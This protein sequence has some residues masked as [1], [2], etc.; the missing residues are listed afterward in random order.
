MLLYQKGQNELL[1][2]NVTSLM[3]LTVVLM[4]SYNRQ[5]LLDLRP[6]VIGPGSY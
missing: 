1:E 6:T 4:P 3:T 2:M 5:R